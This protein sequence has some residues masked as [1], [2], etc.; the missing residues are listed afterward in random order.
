MTRDEQLRLL[1]QCRRRSYLPVRIYDLKHLPRCHTGWLPQRVHEGC[2]GIG[3]ES[4][5]VTSGSSAHLYQYGKGIG[6]FPNPTPTV[7]SVQNGQ[8]QAGPLLSTSSDSSGPRMFRPR[9]ARD[10]EG[11][12]PLYSGGSTRTWITWIFY[13]PT[14]INSHTTDGCDAYTRFLSSDQRFDWSYL[15]ITEQ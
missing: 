6:F 4:S 15:Y 3:F 10:Y 14:Q 7:G 2:A 8:G 1:V 9:L 12:V 13:N 5:C 11:Y